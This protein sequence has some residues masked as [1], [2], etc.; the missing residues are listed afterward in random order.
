MLAAIDIATGK[1]T[2]WVNKTRKAVDFIT[3]MNKVIKEYSGQRLCVVMAN[4]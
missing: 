3:F 2:A 1:A 4:R